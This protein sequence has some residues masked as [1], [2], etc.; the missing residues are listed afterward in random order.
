MDR[1]LV[2]FCYGLPRELHGRAGWDRWI[3]RQAMA[4][5]LPP[6]VQWRRV[7]TDYS[8]T[9][10]H[11]RRQDFAPMTELINGADARLG[12]YVDLAALRREWAWY[13]QQEQL[14]YRLA[15]TG[16]RVWRAALLAAWFQHLA[17]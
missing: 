2:E 7:K 10:I 9:L 1:R 17:P 5:V 13:Q 14:T 12:R 8:A 3:V 11:D 16:Y 4:G 6:G 15:V